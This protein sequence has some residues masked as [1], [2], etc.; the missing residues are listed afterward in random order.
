MIK[1]LKSLRNI[2]VAVTIL[3]AV[4]LTAG[5]TFAFT[6][7]AQSIDNCVSTGY[8]NEKYNRDASMTK[9]AFVLKCQ[10]IDARVRHI[11]ESY[12][13]TTPYFITDVNTTF[14]G[15]KTVGCVT[16]SGRGDVEV[17]IM[18]ISTNADYFISLEHTVTHEY[19]HTQTNSSE[20]ALIASHPEVWGNL[21]PLEA[22]AD[23]GVSYFQPQYNGGFYIPNCNQL[24]TEIAY[25]AITN[26]LTEDDFILE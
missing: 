9:E 7:Q 10:T 16:F 11:L 19:V 22:V 6:N 20:R 21:E 4:A 3:V 2:I 15:E 23:C 26:T 5:I 17:A 12:G 14:C 13:N 24:Q 25:K 1:I 8:E 18:S